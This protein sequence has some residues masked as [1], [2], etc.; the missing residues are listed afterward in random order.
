[1]PYPRS[2][3]Y[4]FVVIAVIIGGFWPTY[5]SVWRDVPWQFHAHGIASSVWVLMVT[6]Q[7]WSAHRA[8][9]LHRAIGLTSL[10]LFPFLTGG[11]AAIIDVTAKG[12]VAAD[13]PF[14]GA[15]GGSLLVIVLIAM[16]AYLTLFYR[17]LKFRRTVW[18][19]SGYMLATPLILFESAFHRLMLWYV[20]GATDPRMFLPGISIAMS[21]ELI[22]IAAIWFRHRTRAKPFVVAAGFIA[23]QMIG[24]VMFK[25]APP[26]IAVL[27]AIGRAPHALVVSIG[28]VMGMLTSWAGWVAGK[29]L[30]S[31]PQVSELPEPIAR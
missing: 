29:P 27:V 23:A 26:I 9:Q 24:M 4:M 28:F 15:N 19:H 1:M 25:D 6:W 18:L 3:L 10:A 16:L 2:Y 8:L 30:S 11:L 31:P 5:F 21:V 7:S 22:V 17:A 20:P 13:D 14:R 12:F